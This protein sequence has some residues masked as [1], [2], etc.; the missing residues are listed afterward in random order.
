MCGTPRTPQGPREASPGGGSG[1][2]A[3]WATGGR[4]A[5]AWA[6]AQRSARGTGLEQK[7]RTASQS[8]KG[9]SHKTN[10]WSLETPSPSPRAKHKGGPRASRAARCRALRVLSR[11]KGRGS[12]RWSAFKAP[13]ARSGLRGEQRPPSMAAMTRSALN[14]KPKAAVASDSV[15]LRGR[16]GAAGSGPLGGRGARAVPV[17]S[18][19]C[20]G[21][22]AGVLGPGGWPA[23][24]G[25]A[26]GRCAVL[27]Y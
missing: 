20:R 26:G 6:P 7:R 3:A 1:G 13:R 2:S 11:R 27:T 17:P 19:R 22:G 24:S 8:G 23:G 18:P 10:D 4:A 21:P 14:S 16:P 12:G 15:A 25:E 5:R 9:E